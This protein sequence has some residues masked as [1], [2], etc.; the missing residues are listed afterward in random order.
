M[1]YPLN[2][3]ECASQRSSPTVV[4]R[5]AQQPLHFLRIQE[6]QRGA[7]VVPQ[8]LKVYSYTAFQYSMLGA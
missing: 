8:Q 6:N 2:S 7:E 3:R 4:T 1:W 5:K